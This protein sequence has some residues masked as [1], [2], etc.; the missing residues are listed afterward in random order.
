M[1]KIY[2]HILIWS[3]LFL[4]TIISCTSDDN[5]DVFLDFSLDVTHLE[6]G[7]EVLDL[8]NNYREELGLTSLFFDKNEILELA[9]SHSSYM[10]RENKISHDFFSDR[11]AQLRKNGAIAVSENVAFGYRNAE[12]VFQA[13]LSSESHRE[14]IEGNYTRTAIGILQ[15]DNGVFFYTQIFAKY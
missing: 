14:A 15:N 8:I 12:S 6:M 9:L 7:M 5:G 1:K 11:S 3:I 13:W 10:I 2:S 4:T